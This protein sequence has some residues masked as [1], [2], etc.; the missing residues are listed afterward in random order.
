VN[1]KSEPEWGAAAQKFT[2]GRGVDHILEIGGSGTMPQS[3]AAARNGGHI[4]VIG[5]LAGYAGPISTVAIMGKQ[6]KVI[7]LTV[8]SRRQQL[9]LIRAID[10]AGYKPVLDKHFPLQDLAS[11]FR[12]QESNTHF[13]KIVVDI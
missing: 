13:G 6:L 5:V 8:G 7:G 12:H 3:I 2:N 9:D 1:Y 10:V 4:A 11:A